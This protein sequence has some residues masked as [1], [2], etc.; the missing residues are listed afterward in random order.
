MP[1]EGM[2]ILRIPVHCNSFLNTIIIWITFYES[3]DERSFAWS[4]VLLKH[5]DLK[6]HAGVEHQVLL[7][8]TKAAFWVELRDGL[9]EP[10][11][12][13]Q[14]GIF[15]DS[16]WLCKWLMM[17]FLVKLQWFQ[18]DL[19]WKCLKVSVKWAVSNITM[20]NAVHSVWNKRFPSKVILIF[21][22]C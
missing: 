12:T 21:K 8:I 1:K 5:E 19:K 4:R 7:L 22:F 9:N 2:N 6:A 3:D 11:G 18:A 13:F 16:L 10:Y 15:C 14:P 17:H 20:F